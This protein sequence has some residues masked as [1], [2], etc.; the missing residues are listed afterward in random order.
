MILISNQI[1]PYSLIILTC[2]SILLIIGI[3]LKSLFLRS[4]SIIIIGVDLIKIFFIEF[5]EISD[6]YKGVVFILI[7]TLFLLLSLFYNKTKHKSSR[8]V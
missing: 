2:S 8:R 6:N 4:V 1:L 3:K 5:V 7:G